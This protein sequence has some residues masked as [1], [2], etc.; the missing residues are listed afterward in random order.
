ML[1]LSTKQEISLVLVLKTYFLICNV[2]SKEKDQMS[3]DLC[4]TQH[5]SVCTKYLTSMSSALFHY[6]TAAVNIGLES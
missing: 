3:V 2:K 1:N 4:L 6:N 5:D